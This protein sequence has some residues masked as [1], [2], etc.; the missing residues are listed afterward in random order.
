MQTIEVLKGMRD[1]ERERIKEYYRTPPVRERILEFLGDGGS[2]EPTCMYI[3]HYGNTSK[4]LPTAEPVSELDKILGYNDGL[5]RSLWD[6][7]SLIADVDVEYVNFDFPAEAYL[8]PYRTFSLQQNVRQAF[9]D[10]LGEYGIEP[11]QLLTGR[12]Y[13]YVWS[14]P[15]GSASFNALVD[16]GR[17]GGDL[18]DYYR[19]HKYFGNAR[20]DDTLGCAYTGLGMVIEYFA[21]RIMRK[22]GGKG[23]LSVQL[24]AVVVGPAERG[25]EIVS[26]DISEY[27]DPLN[28]RILQT[29]FTPYLKP[30]LKGGILHDGIRNEIPLMTPV[31]LNGLDVY[32]GLDTMRSL[33]QSASYACTTHTIIPEMGSPMAALIAAYRGS[34]LAGFHKDFYSEEHEPVERW[35]NTY[36]HLDMNLLPVCIS[37]ILTN[38]NDLLLTPAGMQ[39][40]VRGLYAFGWHPRHIAG[41]IRSKFERNFGWGNEWYAYNA[42]SRADVYT[43]MFAGLI[44]V[45]LDELIDFNCISTKEKGYCFKKEGYCDLSGLRQA[46]LERSH[47]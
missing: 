30:L 7:H 29:P 24:T 44:T 36:D 10:T 13:H 23:P 39:Q 4:Y 14:I 9:V 34:P 17:I 3:A 33:S 1:V 45:G 11:L 15:K 40:V 26:L 27:A 47:R 35:S 41:L 19:S 2:R 16:I 20:V 43:R 22:A 31:P 6:Q 32:K 21:H 37:T 28:T 25:R 12:G 8:D 46:A 42:S 5:F 18:H 38:P